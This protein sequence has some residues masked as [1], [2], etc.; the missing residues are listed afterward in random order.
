MSDLITRALRWYTRDPDKLNAQLATVAAVLMLIAAFYDWRYAG[1]WLSAYFA[2][3]AAFF[4][5]QIVY[6]RCNHE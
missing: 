6:R 4:A 3:V 5:W 2:C 1:G